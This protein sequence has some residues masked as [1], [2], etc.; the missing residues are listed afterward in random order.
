MKRI[1]RI[2]ITDRKK[3]KSEWIGEEEG[4]GIPFRKL[5]AILK[6]LGT[7]FRDGY[8]CFDEKG[9]QLFPCFSEEK[10]RIFFLYL[11]EMLKKNYDD[12]EV[13]GA[14]QNE[15]EQYLWVSI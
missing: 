4:G 10:T 13:V 12:L 6:R 8:Y 15:K 5:K 14:P 9:E 3:E 1:E 2:K 11:G 7:S